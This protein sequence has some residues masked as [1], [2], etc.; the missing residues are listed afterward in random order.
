MVQPALKAIRI[1][2]HAPPGGAVW[3]FYK[4]ALKVRG[5]WW[6][7]ATAAVLALWMLLAASAPVVWSVVFRGYAPIEVFDHVA[8]RLSGH[9]KLEWVANPPLG[10]LAGWFGA[11][12]A[13]VRQQW[14]FSVPPLDSRSDAKAAVALPTI[15]VVRG[16]QIIRVASLKE[17]ARVAVSGDE[18]HLSA[19]DHHGETAVFRGKSVAIRGVGGLARL[20]APRSLAEGK[21]QLVLSNGQFRVSHLALIGARAPD[22]NGA[23]IRFEGGTLHVEDCVFWGADSGILT[24]SDTERHASTVT[25]ERSEF[26][27]L[28][29]GDGYSHALYVGRLAE[30]RVEASYF[31]HAFVGHLL[32]SRARVNHIAYSRFTDEEGGRASYELSFPNGGEVTLTGLIVAQSASTENSLLVSYGEEGDVWPVNRLT[33]LNNTLVNGLPYGGRLLRVSGALQGG[34]VWNNLVVGAGTWALPAQ[35]NA[36][37]NLHAE[38]DELVAP[39]RGDFRLANPDRHGWLRPQGVKGS[40]AMLLQ[41]QYV[42]PRRVLPLSAPD[43]AAAVVGALPPASAP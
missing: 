16:N 15:Q 6:W 4:G 37:N 13:S 35:V 10:W 32:K 40:E 8:K 1:G 7:W 9:P 29:H 24:T 31:H 17:A 43:P 14:P 2:G 22:K 28:G 36:G 11:T 30:L 39:W 23:G 33:M 12:P 26:G 41:R 27:Y 20:H 25:V 34:L 18:I 5:R 3:V 38:W 21:A 19:G 42:H